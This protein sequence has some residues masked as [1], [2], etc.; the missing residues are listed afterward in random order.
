MTNLISQNKDGII[1]VESDTGVIFGVVSQSEI[2]DQNFDKIDGDTLTV[3]ENAGFQLD[4]D[5]EGERTYIEFR[6]ENGE[7]SKLVFSEGIAFLE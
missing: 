3:L 6:H 4:Q 1:H 2:L 5:W 7:V